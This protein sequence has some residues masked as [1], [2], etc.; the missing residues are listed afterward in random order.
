MSDTL[1]AVRQYVTVSGRELFGLGLTAA[2]VSFILRA[3]DLL[4][5]RFAQL[6]S[7]WPLLIMFVFLFLLGILAVWIAKIVAARV[8]YAIQYVPHT[9]GLIIGAILAVL[10]AGWLPLFL[11]G[12]FAFSRPERLRIGK[13]EGWYKGWEV[14][15]IAAVFPLAFTFF[16]LPINAL[17]LL[18]GSEIYLELIVATWLVAL[19]ACLPAPMIGHRTDTLKD[20]YDMVKRLRGCSFGLDVFYASGAWFLILSAYVL[21]VGLLAWVLTV[22]AWPL[23]IWVYALSVVLAFITWWIFGKF[24]R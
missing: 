15:L 7:L 10:S 23:G 11:P 6:D 22:A 17:Y 24:F 18:S 16:L 20:I 5:E 14:G 13:H 8:G 21:V 4:F 3:R 19:F 9:H 1:Y 2:V 12:G